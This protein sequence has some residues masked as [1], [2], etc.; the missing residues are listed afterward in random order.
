MPVAEQAPPRHGHGGGQQDG[1]DHPERRGDRQQLAAARRQHRLRRGHG[2][3]IQL[4]NHIRSCQDVI[5]ITS[6]V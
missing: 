3:Q 5:G 1:G 2:G 6:A 4:V